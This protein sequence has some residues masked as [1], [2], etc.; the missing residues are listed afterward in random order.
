MSAHLHHHLQKSKRI[1]HI[2]KNKFKQDQIPKLIAPYTLPHGTLLIPNEERLALK[3]KKLKEDGCDN[4][5]ILTDYDSTLTTHKHL[6]GR[7]AATSF[8]ALQDS[9][10]VPDHIRTI[11]RKYYEKYSVIELDNQMP[12]EDKSR[13]MF[14]WW[15]QNLDLFS[16]I[17]M[18]RED[19]IHLV[20]ESRILF[21]NGVK[22]LLETQN[23]LKMP[24]YIVSGG[25][26]DIIDASFQTILNNDEITSEHAHQ[27]WAN[28]KIFSNEFNYAEDVM[29][30]YKKPVIH[31]LNKQQFIYDKHK[32]FRKNVII[33][34][35]FIEDVS[36]VRLSEHETVLNIGYL[37]CMETQGHQLEDFKRM[38]DLVV[39]YDGSLQVVNFLLQKLFMDSVQKEVQEA[40]DNSENS[41]HL[42]R[43]LN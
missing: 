8:R 10:F 17:K 6:D 18:H 34:G 15:E 9:R 35:D 31:V 5:Q 26:T 14:D 21:R 16:T 40:V 29:I 33:M 19:F 22:E 39:L 3:L 7:K 20:L 32:N 12:H 11:T 36:M 42:K 37:N 24:F 25:I 1:Q 28:T 13:H 23:K 41:T 43:L 30:G 2:I 38:F 4:V 27:C